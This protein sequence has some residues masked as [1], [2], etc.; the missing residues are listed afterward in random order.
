MAA[1]APNDKLRIGTNVGAMFVRYCCMNGLFWYSISS[2]LKRNRSRVDWARIMIQAF[3]GNSHDLSMFIPLTI[4]F[5][6]DCG[7]RG[8]PL[9]PIR[10]VLALEFLKVITL[11]R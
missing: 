4:Q 10:K 8:A 7:P 9:C 11:S 2:Q 6:V 5:E 1:I 3:W